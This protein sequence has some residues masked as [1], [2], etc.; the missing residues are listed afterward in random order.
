[1]YEDDQ[2]LAFR[3]IAP[4]A[5]THILV[6]PKVK[7]RLSRLINAD[8]DDKAILGHLMYISALVARQEK[9]EEGWRL[10]VNNG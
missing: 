9:L 1:M 7:G 10:V 5:P 6:I 3:D 2:A 4:Q 8:K